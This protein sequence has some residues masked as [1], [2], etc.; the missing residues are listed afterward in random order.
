MREDVT[1]ERLPMS[2]RDPHP[3]PGGAG[4][5]PAPWAAF[6]AQPDPA[7]AKK[8]SSLSSDLGSLCDLFIFF[9]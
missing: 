3:R 8:R 6:P 9:K 2:Q 7:P 1:Q 5:Q 4:A